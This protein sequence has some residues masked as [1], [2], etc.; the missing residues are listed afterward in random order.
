MKHFLLF[1]SVTVCFLAV[2]SAFAQESGQDMVLARVNSKL[3]TRRDVEK[4]LAFSGHTEQIEKHFRG[5]LLEEKKAE[6]LK[7]ALGE[8]V[9]DAVIA[10]NAKCDG[11][12]LDQ[13]DAKKIEDRLR[14]YVEQYGSEANC[15]LDLKRRGS[16]LKDARELM[17]KSVLAEKYITTKREIARY[18]SPK[19][20]REYFEKNGELLRKI[21][22]KQTVVI[23][24]IVVK[25][26][27]GLRT[28]EKANEQMQ[29]I[30]EA[31]RGGEDFGSLARKYSE[32]PRRD[33]GGMWEPVSVSDFREEVAA[34]IAKLDEGEVSEVIDRG[35]NFALV[36]VEKKED[37]FE[38]ALGA[39]IQ[40]LTGARQQ[41]RSRQVMCELYSGV[42][43]ELF[44]HGVSPSDICPG[45]SMQEEGEPETEAI[46]EASP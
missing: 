15:E 38:A 4:L 8:L 39:I 3:I 22:G 7:Y 31:I 9:F 1:M 5:P 45:Y 2:T 13:A 26:G 30:K 28:R 21:T 37:P 18:V 40:A 34:E 14:Q 44:L 46:E 42:E 25:Y 6:L 19:E 11:V 29:Q 43:I 23:R 41:E 16:S 12:E 24:Q 17:T 32:G 27:R 33:E 36:K 10:I 35:D 20:A